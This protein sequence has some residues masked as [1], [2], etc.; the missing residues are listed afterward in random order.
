MILDVVYNHIGPGSEAIGA[1]G[2]YFTDRYDTFWGDGDRLLAARR[3]RVGDPERRAVGPRLPHRRPAPRRGPRDLRRAP[4]ARPARSW[5]SASAPSDP[6]ALVISEMEPD[7]RAPIERVGPRRAVGGRAPPRAPRP[8]DRRARRLL[9]DYGASPGSQRELSQRPRAERLVICAQNHDQVGNR[10]LGDRLPPDAR[11]ARA[12][13]SLFAP[14][15]PLALHG[16]GVR[17]ARPV[18]VLH[19]PHRPVIADGD[20]RGP[21]QGVR[22]R[23]RR[24]PA[25]TC[26][27]RRTP[28]TFER[29][30]L[31]PRR[32]PELRA[33]YREL[34]ALRRELPREVETDVDE[35]ATRADACAAATSS[36]SRTSRRRP[37]S[38]RA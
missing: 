34:L 15:T 2:P 31:D 28:A 30:K 5:P 9:R 36:S 3:A 32:R 10:A 14:Q 24:S 22:E 1:F 20:A 17:R 26:P 8:A 37:W 35:R 11:R 12:A 25:R 29:S 7:D 23:S 4:H 33:F 27:T 18:P 38:S 19:R 6:R 16:R 21:P 13:R